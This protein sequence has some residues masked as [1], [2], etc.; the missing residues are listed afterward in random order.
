MPVRSRFPNPPRDYNQQWGN[1]FVRTLELSDQNIWAILQALQTNLVT[2]TVALS[3]PTTV[4]SAN[5]YSV[6]GSDSA[7]IVNRGA[8]VT[9]T[10]LAAADVPGRSLLVK[11]IAAHTVV[12]ATSNVV[13]LAGGAAGTA[14]LAA[15]AGKWAELRSDGSVWHIMAAN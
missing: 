14:I 4:D 5:T 13:P 1:Q 7:L 11:T 9:L 10:L 3:A 6:T 12:S 15:T 2:Q 8:T